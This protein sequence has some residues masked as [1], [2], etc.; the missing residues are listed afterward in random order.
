MRRVAKSSALMDGFHPA[1]REWFQKRFGHP[2]PPQK[3]GW[4]HIREGKHVLIL[5]PTGSGKTLAAFLECLNRL[6]LE[7]S[8]GVQ[9]DDPAGVQILYVSPLKALNND[10]RRN[11]A[12]PLSGIEQTAKELGMPL[13]RITTAL[14]T[15]DT[16]P[17]ERRA[18]L[19]RPPH[20]LITTPES[21]YLLLTGTQ[22]RRIL[23]TVRYCIVDEIHAM[24]GGKRGVH[25]ALS[26]ERLA[27][28]AGDFVRIG[29]S[30]TQRPLEEI[31]RFLGGPSPVSVVDTGSRKDLDVKVVCPTSF[32]NAE[33]SVWPSVYER[34]IQWI[35][36]HRSTIIFVNGRGLAERLALRLNELA[37]E[38]QIVDESVNL[39]ET[40]HG[41][42]SREHRERVEEALKA[43]RLRAIV[44]TSSLELGIDIGTVD[45]VVQIESPKSSARGLQRV[46]RSGHALGQASKGRIVP[47]YD[48]DLIEAAVIAQRM[49]KG[50]VEKTQV[51]QNC[52]D[53][54]AQH[55]V[56]MVVSGARRADDMFA[57]VRRA[58]PFQSLD[59]ETFYSV[60]RMLGG[61][62]TG[63]A[64]LHFD[65]G[66]NLVR[67]SVGSQ[68]V[69]TTSGGTIPDRG[70]YK[71]YVARQGEKPFPLGELDE[72]FVFETPVGDVFTL[73]NGTWK[74]E[75]IER[76]R[77]F[78]SP[79]VGDLARKQPF[80]KGEGLGR[81][82][83]LG[84]EVGRFLREMDGQ[85]ASL[86][87]NVF[88]RGT[89][90]SKESTDIEA[91]DIEPNNTE[92]SNVE[93]A[94]LRAFTENLKQ[95][96][97]LDDQACCNL[98]D[99]LRR[100]R[101][102]TG[103]LPNDQHLLL[104]EY[105][106]PLGDLYVVL[107][108]PFGG[109]VHAAWAMAMQPGV[110]EN[111]GAEGKILYADSGVAVKLPYAISQT[112]F[113]KEASAAS[114][115][116]ES[117]MSIQVDELKPLIGQELLRSQL[118]VRCFRQAAMRSLLL[119]R[120]PGRRLPLWLQRL[121][122]AD[123]LEVARKEPDHP[124]VLEALREALEDQM[125]LDGLE[126]VVKA[127]GGGKIQVTSLRR[128]TPSPFAL[129]LIQ[130]FTGAFMYESDE[131]RAD[132]H[133]GQSAF[134]QDRLAALMSG[135]DV[136]S[137]LDSRA[138]Q[139][140]EGQ[141]QRTAKGWRARNPEELSD[142]L[143]TL[144]DLT[145]EEVCRR[146]EG[147]EEQAAKFLDVLEERGE[148]RRV[149][150]AGSMRW[151]H[152]DVDRD[153]KAL[154]VLYA[155]QRGPF[156]AE[157]IAQRYNFSPAE[158]VALLEELEADGGLVRGPF[159]S[160]DEAW[161]HPRT[162]ERI[163]QST[164]KGLKKTSAPADPDKLS[165]YLFSW[166]EIN[167]S[168]GGAR[169]TGEAASL[170]DAIGR[171]QGL[172][173]PAEVWEDYVFPAR[174]KNFRPQE[175][176]ELIA[177]GEVIW[178]ASGDGKGLGR[179]AF[180]LREHLPTAPAMSSA[181]MPSDHGTEIA[182]YL[183]R[184]GASF[185]TEIASGLGMGRAETLRG[186]SELM[187][188]GIITNDAFEPIR[189]AVSGVR[190]PE[191]LATH[192][193]GIPTSGPGST[194]SGVER[195][196]S[197]GTGLGRFGSLRRNRRRRSDAR[198]KARAV[199]EAD[200][201]LGSGR[202]SLTPPSVSRLLN[203][204][205]GVEDTE[206]NG[207]KGDDHG[208]EVIEWWIDT[209]LDRYGF[210]CR[211]LFVL[212]RQAELWTLARPKLER[213]EWAGRLQRGY[214]VAELSGPQFARGDAADQ[215]SALEHEEKGSVTVLS[216]LDPVTAV[217]TWATSQAT[218]AG[219]RLSREPGNFCVFVDGR[220]VLWITGYGRQIMSAFGFDDQVEKVM[221]DSVKAFARA[222]LRTPSQR[223]SRRSITVEQWDGAAV[224]NSRGA[225]ILA[226]C[227][228]SKGPRGYTLWLSDLA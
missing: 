50:E 149:D 170:L 228:F 48:D 98:I 76:D 35:Q 178:V 29:L 148:V 28:L 177:R 93:A 214:Y 60:L 18:M 143:A 208:E 216:A 108:S 41:S 137:L 15:G 163:R 64:R 57:L 107:H 79:A 139:A 181:A 9:E 191:A 8:E 99:Y 219:F 91:A 43:G 38:H 24:A 207:S 194:T 221:I 47:Q 175:L 132:R 36:E 55:C 86:D 67:P 74:V 117:L 145:T 71:L 40:H 156:Y 152:R 78:V 112:H 125:D 84:V 53:V 89:G 111:F 150:L 190:P 134:S 153:P 90:S 59:R 25:L 211:D 34:L 205:T 56:S 174:V 213:E 87:P 32:R 164:L 203:V 31:A 135:D 104:E 114:L 180:F 14:R 154:A 161:C 225:S 204:S 63:K 122:A 17:A 169:V 21:L 165:R 210:V 159:L 11:L 1:I 224:E 75:A 95:K 45:L 192:E 27:E 61:R 62:T 23:Q 131:P 226:A 51:P 3:Q 144:G 26:L 68:V 186:L 120:S 184:F 182:A 33:G 5:A 49:I 136:P 113:Q 179:V 10:I 222:L 39:V 218:S 81:P 12:E 106:D 20:I 167:E 189:K 173:L 209:L 4:P 92:P 215:L 168:E 147:T 185:A 65:E 72:E 77:V 54:L 46:G 129:G 141:L 151:I 105:R 19:R 172:F 157:D 171:M 124:L 140:I 197:D 196:L 118:F 138:I 42:L 88:D 22:S 82:Y 188:A 96:Y 37:W 198:R 183:S 160:Q 142:L 121:K 199:V 66:S 127:I 85:L 166:H 227:G 201:S 100:Q 119:P 176:D 52:L 16:S 69:A 58:Y 83:E 116:L 7:G 115:F 128:S 206:R 130:S 223:S 6:Y 70:Y 80:W 195:S 109:R 200:M 123:L 110:N 102:A 101:E 2:S 202:W 162:L 158:T 220:P 73:G 133:T 103:F 217:V 97:A 155:L 44:A 187:W 13:P 126:K 30:A 193:L 94:K 146:V 212:E